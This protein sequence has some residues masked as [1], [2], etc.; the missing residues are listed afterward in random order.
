MPNKFN[1]YKSSAGSGKTFTLTKEYLKLALLDPQKKYKVILAITFTVKAT[2]EMKARILEACHAFSNSAALT[3]R[4]L[5]LMEAL[6][7]DES[8]GLPEALIR[9]RASE[10]YTTILHNYSDFAVS[11]IDSFS[12]RLIR[13]FAFELNLPVTFEVEI[14]QEK[15][16]ELITDHLLDKIGNDEGLTQ[17]LTNLFL[18]KLEEKDSWNIRDEIERSAHNMLNETSMEPLRALSE[19]KV[20]TK[21]VNQALKALNQAYFAQQNTLKAEGKKALELIAHQGLGFKDF[22]YSYIPKYFESIAKGQFKLPSASVAKMFAGEADWYTKTQRPEVKAV[23]DGLQPSLTAISQDIIAQLPTWKLR[24]LL[25]AEIDK[26][27]LFLSLK[28]LYHDYRK[29]ENIVLIS[30]FNQII[31]REVKGQPAPFIFEKVGDFYAHLLI[32]EFQ[33]T[34]VMQ[35]QNLLPMLEE[36]MS[37][38]EWNSNLV[39]GDSKQAIYRW[40][41][42]ETK[43]LA[44]LP[45]LMG[46]EDDVVLQ[47]MEQALAQYFQAHVLAKNFRSKEAIVTF[48]NALFEVLGQHP[49]LA[50]PAIYEDAQQ[51]IIKAGS[52]G[53][54]TVTAF[55]TSK[56]DKEAA[57]QARLDKLVELIQSA[58]ERGY[59]EEQITILTRYKKHTP[60]IAE[61]LADNG[62]QFSSQE[63]LLLRRSPIV[64]LYPNLIALMR[65][66][67]HQVHQAAVAQGLWSMNLFNTSRHML[68]AHLSKAKYTTFNAFA[69]WMNSLQQRHNVFTLQQED[70]LTIWETLVGWL[71]ED[72]RNSAYISFF[73]DELWAFIS[74]N[75]NNAEAF[76]DWWDDQKDK[77]Y[78]KSSNQA[79][80]VQIMTIHKSKGLEFDIVLM[81]FAD[82]TFSQPSK[83]ESKWVNVGLEEIAPISQVLMPLKRDVEQTPLAAHFTAN[84]EAIFLDNLNLLYVATTRAVAELHILTGN[85]APKKDSQM[86][87]HLFHY[88]L[89]AMNQKDSYEL[90]QPTQAAV[91]EASSARQK[92][93]VRPAQN[94]QGQQGMAIKNKASVIWSDDVR[95]KI[96]FGELVH[97][98]LAE[99][100]SGSDLLTVLEKAVARGWLS[101]EQLPELEP[102]L[103][104]VVHAPELQ[105]YFTDAPN[106]F[107]EQPI[108]TPTGSPLIPDRMLLDMSSKTA[109]ILD[110]KTGQQKSQHED[111]LKKYGQLLVE[112]GYSITELL[113][114]YTD[115]LQI[116]PV[117]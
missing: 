59:E 113:L 93:A 35:F 54:V 20:D 87:S 69:T 105:D 85:T 111:Q 98:L 19:E 31:A 5:A 91:V 41:G 110:F 33:D 52:G 73:R 51:E 106:L 21:A 83:P 39:V 102:L 38:P 94:S 8:F 88:F 55:E 95:E 82:W 101:T 72:Q 47:D 13:S 89:E 92:F 25:R 28:Q 24:Q 49:E 61:A 4:N 45:K 76:L 75:G 56:E 42:G 37:Q 7:E 65:Q 36:S 81:P 23:I 103:K 86:A 84:K 96:D 74:K 99:T 46:S 67:A 114:V 108:I 27:A 100:R 107:T 29:S 26:I 66:P 78:I 16:V 48:N 53:W 77:L 58:K 14:D 112:M 70:L 9:E 116:K 10:L 50:Y 34:S 57:I 40:R 18:T 60:A 1:V 71:P 30:E 44:Q 79:G 90:G 97:A 15:V 80:G 2:N 64:R 32:D 12:Q 63:S 6:Q 109:R 3:G 11:T 22:A 62:I 104:K 68:N 115:S 43:Q 117:Q 17:L